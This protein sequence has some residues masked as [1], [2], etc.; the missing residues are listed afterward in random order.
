VKTIDYYDLIPLHIKDGAGFPFHYYE[1]SIEQRFLVDSLLEIRYDESVEEVTRLAEE[2]ADLV[3][4]LKDT[5]KEVTN[6][7]I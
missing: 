5:L 4:E 1:L 7:K 2:M 6:A 3:V